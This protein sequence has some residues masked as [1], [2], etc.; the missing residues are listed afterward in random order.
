MPTPT[1]SP[2]VQP[3]LNVV[4]VHPPAY[5]RSV[6]ST[7]FLVVIKIIHIVPGYAEFFSI[8]QIAPNDPRFPT[9]PRTFVHRIVSPYIIAPITHP[10]LKAKRP[11]KDNDKNK[12]PATICKLFNGRGLITLVQ[13]LIKVS[14]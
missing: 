13:Q 12:G 10:R 7:L 11:N 3:L 9:Q 4:Y 2:S 5:L 8:G 6:N 1:S 14:G